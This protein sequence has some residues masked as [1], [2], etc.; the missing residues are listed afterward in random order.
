MKSMTKEQHDHASDL[1]D[2]G[3][4]YR[5]VASATG[6]SKSTLQRAF[7]KSDS[8]EEEPD[9]EP[10]GAPPIV[11]STRTKEPPSLGK[12]ALDREHERGMATIAIEREKL[13]VQK[14]Q[15]KNETQGLYLKDCEL[16]NQADEKMEKRHKRSTTLLT[17]YKM[18]LAELRE[19]C[20]DSDWDRDEVDEYIERVEDLQERVTKLCSQLGTDEEELA[21]YHNLT[22]L[23]D[24][25]QEKLDD[26]AGN[27]IEFDLDRSE[28]RVLEDLKLVDFDQEHDEETEDDDD[29]NT[30]DE[31]APDTDDAEEKG[32][33][34]LNG[35]TPSNPRHERELVLQFNE[36]L[37][38]LIDDCQDT[39]WKTKDY[40]D[41][42]DRA[43]QL[44][45]E[46]DEYI[47]ELEGAV[48]DHALLVNAWK[49]HEY[50]KKG[51][52]AVSGSGKTITVNAT[53]EGK[54]WL[55]SLAVEDFWDETE[56]DAEDDA[57]L[58]RLKGR[59]GLSKP[60]QRNKKGNHAKA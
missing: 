56:E 16:E 47:D 50:V 44:H 25:M 52:E 2:Q 38:E 10:E 11:R 42:V 48:E 21:I 14:Q 41:F 33:K 31:D 37:D 59:R 26:T 22:F 53:D 30:D 18:L 24:F 28:R 39:K 46:I 58:N 49:L 54:E 1:F 9:D 32:K 51:Y 60:L 3:H 29:E 7:A 5:E 23:V 4:S 36:L 27:R 15:V 45:K 20:V 19:N 40:Y 57:Y 12:L 8:S 17:K 35:I 55:E 6:V 13:E 43:D 34:A